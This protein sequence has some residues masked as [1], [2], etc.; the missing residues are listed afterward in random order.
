MLAVGKV[1]LCG[2][3]RLISEVIR[4]ATGPPQRGKSRGLLARAG[5][6]PRDP[7]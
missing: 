7:H 1:E 6:V 5:K 4:E 3:R 2:M